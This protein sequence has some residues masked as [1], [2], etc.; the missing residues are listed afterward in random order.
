MT[1]EELTTYFHQLVE[2]SPVAILVLDP[3]HRVQMCNPAFER[4]FGYTREEL[5]AANLEDLIATSR[6][7]PE[8]VGIWQRVLNGEKVYAATKRCRKDGSVV[9]VEIH[10]IPLIVKGKLIGVYGIYHD[11]SQR[12]EAELALRQ[13][14]SRLLKLQDD[15]RRRIA[16]E[17]HDTTAQT[18]V[19]LTM[20]LTRL[21]QECGDCAPQIS[22]LIKESVTLAEQSAKELRTLSYLLHPP[23]LDDIGLNSA[24]SW[25]ARGFAQRSG[26]QVSL[27]LAADA[28]RLSTELETT[29]FRIVQEGLTN[30]HRHSGSPTAEIRLMLDGNA[31]V[32]EVADSGRGMPANLQ[33]AAAGALG[34]G[35]TG[36]RERVHQLGGRLDILS[37]EHGTRL[38]VWQPVNCDATA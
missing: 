29:M 22:E 13:L 12:K 3:R 36:M 8:A 9:D 10:G 7:T 38:R 11:I 20:N 35:I 24:I 33:G 27:D 1:L 25:Y 34:V 28:G 15:E 37:D 19:A 16:R 21:Q 2:N 14:S 17:L 5:L 30:I 6:F 31:L 26:I 23:T 4:L 32:L 18:L